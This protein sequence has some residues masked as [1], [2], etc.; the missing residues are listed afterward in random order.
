[1]TLIRISV[2]YKIETWNKNKRKLY[3]FFTL[4]QS[5]LFATY[6]ADKIWRFSSSESF[7]II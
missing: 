1:M 7:S 5:S 6:E 3:E 4:V 2:C